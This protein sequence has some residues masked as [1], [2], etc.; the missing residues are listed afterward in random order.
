MA[1]IEQEH[2]RPRKNEQNKTKAPQDGKNVF[3]VYDP[4]APL[5]P[6]LPNIGMFLDHLQTALRPPD[7]LKPKAFHSFGH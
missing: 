1:Q 2:D 5:I 6:V 7:A 3:D 4:K